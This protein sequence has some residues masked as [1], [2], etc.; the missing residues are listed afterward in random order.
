MSDSVADLETGD[1]D[2]G[3]VTIYDI[4]GPEESKVRVRALPRLTRQALHIAWASGRSEFVVATLLQVIAGGGIALLL[5]LGQ[6]GLQAL[7]ELQSG[8]SLASIA[9]WA[10]AIAGV[11][12]IQSFV[13][14][15][16]RERQEVLGEM[17]QRHVEEHILEVAAAVDL[18]GF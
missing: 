7:L 5:L 13:T 16:Q 2:A 4:Q 1:D 17:M 8:Q 12:G 6:Q 9:P 3:P 11:A 10:I 14:A 18:L 15:V